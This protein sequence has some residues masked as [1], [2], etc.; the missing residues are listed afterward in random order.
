[1]VAGLCALL[2]QFL[3]R[4]SCFSSAQLP[5]LMPAQKVAALAG[6]VAAFGYVLLAGFGVPAQRT[7]YM[8][9]V[10]AVALW[11][12]RMA[13]ISHVLACALLVVVVL[14]PW[15]VLWPGF[16]LS[17]GA[18][19][20][21]LY[22]GGAHRQYG[23]PSAVPSA[24]GGGAGAAAGAGSPGLL[25]GRWQA[26][27]ALLKAAGRAQYAV[28][29][30][31]VPLSLLLFGQVS[32][33]SPL[34]N[35]LAIP[36]ISLIVTPLALLGSVLPSALAAG[37]LLAAH[38]LVAWLAQLLEWCA[39]WSWAIWR[40]PIPSLP[41][42][43]WALWGTLWLLAPRGWPVRWLGLAGW[44]PLLAAEPAHPP[45]GGLRVTAFDVGQGMALL[46]ETAQHRLLYD[47][48][49][50][51][52]L[53]ANAGARVLLPYLRARGIPRL[54]MLVVSHSDTDHAGGARAVLDGVPVALLQSSLPAAHPL[55]RAAKRHLPCSAGQQWEWDGV[56]FAFLHPVADSYADPALK[57]NARGCTLKITA[58]GGSMLL[59][60]DIEAAQERARATLRESVTRRRLT[61]TASR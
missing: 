40:A 3:W 32:L 61:R 26:V 14:D 8:L 12:N 5:L 50:S 18:V 60:A 35:A 58:H 1:M 21:L 54:D 51:Y 11:S 36:L 53:D 17:F 10:L 25:A 33:V 56:R 19:G 22:A 30:G 16:W 37:P 9:C 7:L 6:L 47:T 52:A 59:A 44:I 29:L 31:M 13:S 49:P 23:E 24:S 57:P 46:V 20:V 45:A 2:V 42:F 15:A 28:T 4:H 43:C 27:R 34:A 38:A 41:L 39:G 55:R 48:G